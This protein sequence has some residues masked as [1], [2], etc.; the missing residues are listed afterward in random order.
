[1]T[2]F[3]TKTVEIVFSILFAII[4][5]AMGVAVA[6]FAFSGVAA[7]AVGIIILAFVFGFLFL[8]RKKLTSAFSRITKR[9][10]QFSSWKLALILFLV[11]AVT[12]IIFVFLFDIQ[13]DYSDMAKYRLFADQLANDGVIT[14][15]T[16]YASRVH[17]TVFFGYLLSPL[18]KLFGS[19]FKVFTATFSI[20][21]S[22]AMVLIYDILKRYCG[23]G[24]S[25]SVILV[26]CL[27]PMGLFQ[28]QIL[29]HEN[30]L[31]FCHVLALWI[32]LK[33]LDNKY[34]WK[35]IVGVLSA[36]IILCIG[37][38][39]NAAGRVL[40]I[41]F[42]IYAFAKLFEN[43]FSLKK[44]TKFA[45]VALALVVFY[46]G[47]AHTVDKFASSVIKSDDNATL[48]HWGV[49]YG[50]V[51][52]LGLNYEMSG[53]WNEDDNSTYFAYNNFET[54]EE[55]QEYQK[56]LINE[57]IDFF[58]SSP[59]KIPLHLFNK[60]KVLWGSQWFG[61]LYDGGNSIQQFIAGSSIGALIKL[62]NSA[63]FLVLYSALFMIRVSKRNR[64]AP[65]SVT[66]ALHCQMA[67]IGVTCALWLFEVM[68]KYASH[69]HILLFC[70]L[71]FSIKSLFDRKDNIESAT[72]GSNN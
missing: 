69:L 27:S 11:S 1:M 70:V 53:L 66:P 9:I 36:S 31:L 44:L 21:L 37:K 60:I 22:I 61:A 40:V 47:S 12:K 18:V 30:A 46:V 55:A 26:Y 6:E 25:F 14:Q 24:I 38:S 72:A 3:I 39:V 23:K 43:G 52:Y 19:D 33:A 34:L 8:F 49:S 62:L 41:S 63:L 67:V 51:T 50:W 17:Y 32:F 64:K 10:S 15:A 16:D 5:L 54:K 7:V 57:R 48:K 4:L 35:Q 71:A 42:A 59:E 20:L 58:K 13:T 68:P 28:T 2:K 29:I 56:T 65:I 45:C